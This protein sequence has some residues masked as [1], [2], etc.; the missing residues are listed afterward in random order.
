MTIKKYLES[1]ITFVL[2]HFVTHIPCKPFRK[3]CYRIA[4]MKMGRGCHIDMNEFILASHRIKL[5]DNCHIN[6][7][8]F[9]DGRGGVQICNNV[10]ISHYCRIVTG[11]HDIQNHS[12]SY[13]SK[14]VYIRDYVWI[15]IGATILP[16]VTINRGAVICAGAVVTKEVPEYAIVAGIPA[17]IIGHRNNNLDY[18]ISFSELFR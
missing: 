4:G 3:F 12:F 9:I 11:S 5:G 14:P 17:K 2:N 18:T 1:V 15:G 10:S 8:C 13:F 7:S 16:G 6:Q